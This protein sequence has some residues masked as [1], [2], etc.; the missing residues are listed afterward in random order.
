MDQQLTLL[1]EECHE[2]KELLETLQKCED[3]IDLGY[4]KKELD[5]AQQ[6]EQ[7]LRW[8]LQ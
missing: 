4:I 8:L 3:E 2:Y 6:E 7:G 5:K 1:E